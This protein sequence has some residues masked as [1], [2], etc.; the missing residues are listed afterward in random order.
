MVE[1]VACVWQKEVGVVAL[2]MNA[3]VGITMGEMRLGRV[4]ETDMDGLT[5][6]IAT[7]IKDRG[8]DRD[9]TSPLR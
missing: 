9:F 1:V 8:S 6:D 7:G 4:E 2:G 3:W 5:G